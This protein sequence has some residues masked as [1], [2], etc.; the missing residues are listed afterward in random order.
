MACQTWLE[1][2]SGA[3]GLGGPFLIESTGPYRYLN[4]SQK[5]SPGIIVAIGGA[6]KRRFLYENF[7]LRYG[8]GSKSVRLAALP[9]TTDALLDC[10]IHN[11][12][13]P[14]RVKADPAPWH[15]VAHELR[16]RSPDIS[17]IAF[18]LYCSALLPFAASVLL[19]VS[20]LGGLP[21][22][23]DFLVLWTSMSMRQAPTTLVTVI[24]IFDNRKLLPEPKEL[25]LYTSA[26]LLKKLSISE[27]TI[28]YT[29]S[30]T[31]AAVR[32]CFEIKCLPLGME[33][34][35]IRSFVFDA[36]RTAASRRRQDGLDFPAP[37]LESASSR[38]PS[39]TTQATV[40]YLRGSKLTSL[41][42][43]SLTASALFVDAYRAEVHRFRP[44]VIFAERY[45]E[46]VARLEETIA[47]SHF[48]ELV[49]ERFVD[50]AASKW[51]DIDAV[52]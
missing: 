18:S 50:Y 15:Y 35:S 22:V 14:S 27:P 43:V 9:F 46:V 8:D 28:Q 24:L 17:Q 45:R 34:V 40:L 51:L 42:A 6:Q 44:D 48:R 36:F 26:N 13:Q 52:S 41:E 30:R 11:A 23:I 32:Q 49:Q 39:V 47:L 1:L 4:R 19:F 21:G 12:H 7:S 2:K 25:Y 5:K 3:P 10:E 29:R 33:C 37:H 16:H 20:D 31:D 38:P